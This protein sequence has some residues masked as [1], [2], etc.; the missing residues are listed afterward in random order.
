MEIIIFIQYA[1]S[2]RKRSYN[3]PS[4][5]CIH[6]CTYSMYVASMHSNSNKEEKRLTKTGKSFWEPGNH[7]M[8]GLV[9]W[10]ISCEKGTAT[11]SILG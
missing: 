3:L 8:H 5:V 7:T 2:E 11:K 9:W 10:Y 6:I 4:C 1:L